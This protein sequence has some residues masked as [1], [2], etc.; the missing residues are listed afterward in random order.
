MPAY[1][2]KCRYVCSRAGTGGVKSYTR[3]RPEWVHK[4][5]S[6]RTEC[7]CSLHVKEYPGTQIILGHYS[8]AHDHPLGNANLRFTQIP[9]HTREYIAGLLRLGVA[10]EHILELLHHGVYDD[11]DTFEN[12]LDGAHVASRAE[13]IQLRD[14]RRIETEIEAETV[15]LHPDD[16]LSTLKWVE[17]MDAKGHILG[18]KSKTDPPPP[19]SGLA[20]D[21]F[22]LMIQTRWQQRMFQKY[23]E[24]L[25][26]IDGT[27]NVTMYENLVLTTLVVRDNWGHGMYLCRSDYS[28]HDYRSKRYTC[29]VDA[30]VRRHS[31]NNLLFP[32]APSSPY[33]DDN[34]PQHHI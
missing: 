4:I 22:T 5:P 3:R 19:G 29:R 9:K 16:G 23:G 12:D 8:E 2:R 25:L 15:R 20:Q 34:P 32:Q 18:F 17:H 7:K 13:F 11:E 31:G 28:C 14:V 24:N 1:Q 26:C 10:A 30:C 33:T 6:K 21:L 27:H